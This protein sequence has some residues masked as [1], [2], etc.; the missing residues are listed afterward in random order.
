MPV[1]QK[2]ACKKGAVAF[3]FVPGIMGSRLYSTDREDV[4]WDPAA[5]LHGELSGNFLRETLKRKQVLED[6]N[7]EPEW[8]M[9]AGRMLKKQYYRYVKPV[10]KNVNE[11]V[12]QVARKFRTG[13][14]L[15]D[16]F[17]KDAESRKVLLVNS[18]LSNGYERQDDLLEVDAG[19]ND[20]FRY[21][22]TVFPAEIE[23]KRKRG[24]GEVT[25]DSYGNFLHY[26]DKELSQT[27][28]WQEGFHGVEF[29]T[30]CAGY[31]WM[32]SNEV[33][34]KRIKQ[35]VTQFRQEMAKQAEVSESDVQ[36]IMITHSMGG[37]AARSAHLQG[38]EIDY[39]IHG[40][41]PTNG[42]AATYRNAHCGYDGIAAPILGKNAAEVSAVLAFCQG[43]LELLP[44]HLYQTIQPDY[45]WLKLVDRHK[46]E[47]SLIDA[48]PREKIY[49]FYKTTSQWYSLFS[50]E[51]ISVGVEKIPRNIELV[52]KNYMRRIVAAGRF[53]SVLGGKFHN[54]TT[55]FYSE[56]SEMPSYD[57][58][59]WLE[60]GGC[61][62]NY[63]SWEIISNDNHKWFF[64]AG[65]KEV[66]NKEE[67]KNYQAVKKASLRSSYWAGRESIT[68]KIPGISLIKLLPPWAGGDGTVHKG[69]GRDVRSENGSLISI[70]LQTEEGHQAFFLDHQVSKEITS[71]IQEIM[72]ETYKSKCQVAL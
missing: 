31:N 43:G 27:L 71:R 69:S 6:F 59:I 46:K 33:S 58:C 44:N 55:M 7:V 36:V 34:G 20:H 19:S 57:V 2:C 22:T 9:E 25:W 54:D 70:G 62:G 11:A 51:L 68:G 50:D 67:E 3:V 53:W 52:K 12:I 1:E 60:R 5:G 64:A 24:W 39:M 63:S 37:L 10:T 28:K 29:G 42:S 47:H 66:V 65:N 8:Y 35:K 23:Q 40:A 18:D 45:K 4:V 30:F 26:L 32:L 38:A 56:N 14:S 15:S 61:S 49:D 41:M 17:L 72:Q 13:A 16:L 21:V 48:Y